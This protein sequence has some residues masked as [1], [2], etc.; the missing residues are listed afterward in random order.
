MK[1]LFSAIGPIKRAKFAKKGIADVVFVKL[2]DARNAIISYNNKLLD[3]RELKI[4]LV[5]KIPIAEK[6][7]TIKPAP[8]VATPPQVSTYQY[9]NKSSP[10]TTLI[11]QQ[12]IPPLPQRVRQTSNSATVDPPQNALSKRFSNITTPSS[13]SGALEQE[14][15]LVPKLSQAAAHNSKITVD[16]SVIHQALFTNTNQSPVTFTVKI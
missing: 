3:G 10:Q 4:E 6:L 13:G 5:T 9:I 11:K 2:E 12:N 14:H 16:T 7:S 1:E 8:I 15:K